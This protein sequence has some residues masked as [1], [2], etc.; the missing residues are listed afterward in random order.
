[1]ADRIGAGPAV[2]GT[3][4]YLVRRWVPDV[5]GALDLPVGHLVLAVDAVGV[6]AEQDGD[7]VSG[8]GGDLGGRGPRVEP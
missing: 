5:E 6:G 1:M 4:G 3:A 8:A 7:A 2:R